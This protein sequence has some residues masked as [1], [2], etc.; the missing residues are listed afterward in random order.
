MDEK[1]IQHTIEVLQET[2]QALIAQ[3]PLKLFELSS[4]K[5]HSAVCVQDIESVTLTIVTYTLGKF[6][7]RKSR[8]K[9]K[10]WDILIKKFNSIID[11]AIDALQ[12]NNQEAYR[13]YI[14]KA[15][16]ALE[17]ISPSLKQYTKEVIRNACINKASDIYKHG[18]SMEQTAKLLGI[19]Q[20]E[21]AEYT[22]QTKMA[23]VYYNR[24][25]NEK[26]RI[27]MA[28]EFFE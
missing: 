3:N 24:T 6:L 13:N 22:G 23:D 27:K 9:L 7:E 10:N 2:K 25:L 8:L 18:I 14:L 4:Q 21:L 5:I 15:K 17:S 26:S 28:M 16:L 1:E 11:L 12:K 20:W 19:T